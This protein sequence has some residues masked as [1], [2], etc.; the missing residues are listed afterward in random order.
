MAQHRPPSVKPNRWRRLT[1]GPTLLLHRRPTPAGARGII[2][3][4]PASLGGQNPGQPNN[5]DN[6]Q[7]PRVRSKKR[8]R[9]TFKGAV[10]TS[11]TPKKFNNTDN[12]NKNK[13]NAQPSRVRSKQGQRPTFKGAVKTPTTPTK[14]NNTDNKNNN[15]INLGG[16]ACLVRLTLVGWASSWSF[17]CQ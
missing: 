15:K 17:L 9:P 10:E 8:Q 3:A 6:A 12:K 7:P 1:Y 11:T 14:V 2:E 4:A 5:K 13:E 16:E